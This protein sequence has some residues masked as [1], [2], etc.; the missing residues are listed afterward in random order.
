MSTKRLILWAGDGPLNARDEVVEFII[1]KIDFAL[2]EAENDSC[3]LNELIAYVCCLNGI[4]RETEG[5]HLVAGRV[6]GWHRRTVSVFDAIP[7][8]TEKELRE[9]RPFIAGVFEDLEKLSA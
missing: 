1:E 7:N 6:Q 3:W 4:L 2:N 9:N 5:G 8:Q